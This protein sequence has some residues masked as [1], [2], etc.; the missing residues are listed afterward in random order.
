MK[1]KNLNKYNGLGI[2]IYAFI[3]IFNTL[4]TYLHS[5]GTSR[6]VLNSGSSLSN[7]RFVDS[8][9]TEL[10][11]STNEKDKVID[12]FRDGFFSDYI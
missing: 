7:V 2:I 11:D 1:N 4:P 10:I 3:L 8:N 9:G 5:Q 6:I 12:D